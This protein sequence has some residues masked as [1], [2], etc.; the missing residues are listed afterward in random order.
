MTSKNILIILI[1]ILLLSCSKEEN[2]PAITIAL[3][4]PEQQAGSNTGA[5]TRQI[6][7]TGSLVSIGSPSISNYGFIV[8]RV[9]TNDSIQKEVVL[10]L[11][12]DTLPGAFS[13]TIPLVVSRTYEITAF[14]ESSNVIYRSTTKEFTPSVT[15]AVGTSQ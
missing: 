11:S 6:K 13:S 5:S 15:V 4:T 3:F 2:D 8:N 12:G 7:L 9:S 14:V 10:S 1:S